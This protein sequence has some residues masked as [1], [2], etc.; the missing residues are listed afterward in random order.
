M[1]V[2]F[3]VGMSLDQAKQLLLEFPHAYVTDWQL[4]QRTYQASSRPIGDVVVEF[5]N[6]LRRWR[7]T[8]PYPMRRPRHQS[9]HDAPFLDDVVDAAWPHVQLLGNLNVRDI[10]K[11]LPGQDA[12]L[13]SLWNL[14]CNLAYRGQ[15]SCVGITKAIMLLTEGRIGP[16]FDSTVRKNLRIPRPQDSESWLK[17]LR[18][19]SWDIKGFEQKHN[20]VLESLVP[21]ELAPLSVGRVY[22]M[23]AGPRQSQHNL[24]PPRSSQDERQVDLAGG[25]YGHRDTGFGCARGHE[26][27]RAHPHE[28]AARCRRNVKPSG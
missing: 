9:N 16:A 17:Y 20:I 1:S 19:I 23:I 5:G 7:A 12:A 25:R 6:I 14:F 26:R 13:I 4:W 28:A 18:E 11:T 8:R 21:R 10:D 15:T 24:S 27:P 2:F 3:L 22:D